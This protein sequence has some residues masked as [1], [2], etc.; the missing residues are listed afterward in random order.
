VSGHMGDA[1]TMCVLGNG[2][3]AVDLDGR[4][5]VVTGASHGLGAG[6]SARFLELGLRVAMC[7]RKRPEPPPRAGRHHVLA[8]S[9]DVRDSSGI[10]GFGAA[11]VERFGRIDLWVNNAGV[12]EPIGKL[13]DG[14]PGML[15][16]HISVNVIGVVNGTRTFAR[17]VRTRPGGG[18]LVN[19][20]SGAA[21]TVYPGWAVYCASKAAVDRLTA[22]VAQEEEAQGLRVYSL[23]PGMVDTAMQQKVRESTPEAFP[24]VERFREAKL[25][26]H[27]NPPE[28]V[29]DAVLELAFGGVQIESGSAVRVPDEWE[30]GAD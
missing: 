16:H 10:E 27:F 29:A 6:M 1:A 26:G 3:R 8:L 7:G 12:I 14:D 19:I 13:A 15:A 21:T 20:S 24:A 17:H 11:A 18:A 28:W 4:V 9:A 23:A 22:V 2:A 30:R 25:Y 5:A